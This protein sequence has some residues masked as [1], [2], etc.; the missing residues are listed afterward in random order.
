M[1]NLLDSVV[2]KIKNEVT[3][4]IILTLIPEISKKYNIPQQDLID[5]I[6]GEVRIKATPKE[7]SPVTQ[8]EPVSE[9][10]I[11]KETT[12]GED[13][14]QKIKSKIEECQKTGKYFNVST[15]RP[16]VDSKANRTKLT[17]DDN[18]KIVG[19]KEDTKFTTLVTLL[20]G[21]SDFKVES[22]VKTVSV[23]E[24]KE[25]KTVPV[26]KVESSESSETSDS[27]ESDS[28][29][30]TPV[31]A[32][33]V[34][35]SKKEISMKAVPAKKSTKKEESS[36]SDDSDSSE[37]EKKTPVKSK[38]EETPMKAVPVKKSTKKEE[39]DSEDSDSSESEEKTPVKSKKVESFKEKTDVKEKPTKKEESSESEDSDSSESEEKTPVKS[40]KVESSK[41]KTDVKEKPTKK[42]ETTVK[43]VPVKKEK[44]VESSE[45]HSENV[46]EEKTPVKSKKVES[47]E[48][49]DSSGSDS[50]EETKISIS[51]NK[52]HKKWWN[53]ASG[54]VVEKQGSNKVVVGKIVDD[55][56]SDL[57]QKDIMKCKKNGWDCKETKKSA[58]KISNSSSSSEF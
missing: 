54:F 24:N 25:E 16:I 32:V 4:Q 11:S 39:S 23:T 28:E 57:S 22:S 47:S 53:E 15:S 2:D 21:K 19:N 18:L 49:S 51:Y 13:E 50:E 55:K 8:V 29:V 5:L 3:Q 20:S 6:K 26:K 17:F 48:S 1:T 46:S 36:D 58:K 37:S 10:S 38:K 43:A 45:D 44:K 27:S 33:S 9:E 52:F 34:E 7:T 14:L 40:K 12:V 31:K 42:E 30:K 41:E 56:L 35:K